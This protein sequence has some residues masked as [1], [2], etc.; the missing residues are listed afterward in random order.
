MTQLRARTTR[1]HLA[2]LPPRTDSG[3]TSDH[4]LSPSNPPSREPSSQIPT[5]FIR[6]SDLPPSLAKYP[7][8]IHPHWQYGMENRFRLAQTPEHPHMTGCD[9]TM[10]CCTSCCYFFWNAHFVHLCF[11]LCIVQS[12]DFTNQHFVKE[13]GAC[14]YFSDFGGSCSCHKLRWHGF[15]ARLRFIEFIVRKDLIRKKKTD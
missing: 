12:Y 14:Y 1:N 7:P 8:A 6:L 15:A 11:E 13:V 4:P 5:D 10:Q 2:H 9:L 3:W